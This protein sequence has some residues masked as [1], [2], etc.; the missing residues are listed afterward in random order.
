MTATDNEALVHTDQGVEHIGTG[1]TQR[2]HTVG[3]TLYEWNTS[4]V[5]Y[6]GGIHRVTFPLQQLHQLQL[7]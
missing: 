1:N 2:G 5:E 3:E 6:T 7:N 4:E